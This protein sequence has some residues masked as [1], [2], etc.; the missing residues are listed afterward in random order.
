MQTLAKASVLLYP[1]FD[2][3]QANIEKQL[4]GVFGGGSSSSSSKWGK[5]S[6]TAAG[7]A[8]GTAFGARLG[9]IAG[10]ASSVTSK[11]METLS[12]SLGSAVS[13]TD[14]LNQFPKVMQSLGYSTDEA[15]S[16]MTRLSNGID[17]LPTSLDEI[18]SNTQRLTNV[19][20]DLDYSTSTAIALNDAFLACSASTSDASRGME[21][22]TQMLANGTVDAQS[23]RSLTETMGGS[24][25]KVAEKLGYASTVVGGDLYTALQN[26]TLS[27]DDLNRA[28]I[29]CDTEAGGFADT[30]AQASS[31]IGTSMSIMQTAVTSNMAKVLDKFA[32]S[33]IIDSFAQ[34]FKTNLAGAGDKAAE[35]AGK[36]VG[37]LQGLVDKAGGMDNFV[38]I[39]GKV[40]GAMAGL[41]IGS[42]ILGKLAG[43]A[44]KVG[45]AA[46]K[47]QGFYSKAKL[48][49]T[50]MTTLSGPI[51]AAKTAFEVLVGSIP[52][53]SSV[54]GFLASPIG[55]V[56]GVALA[57]GAGFMYMWS[58]SETFR[59]SVTQLLGQMQTA[60]QPAF[61]AFQQLLVALQPVLGV[62]SGAV[63]NFGAILTGVILPVLGNIALQVMNFVATIMPMVSL[64][65]QTILQT[66][67]VVVQ[68]IQVVI[69][70]A[71]I[72]IQAIVS[73]V[74][75]VIQGI[76][77]AAW[78]IIYNVVGTIFGIILNVISAVL[79][80]ISA[81]I[82]GD[83][84]SI[85]SI[86]QSAW[87]N[88]KQILNNAWNGIK[89]G[90]TQGIS[91]V[92]SAVR[93]IPS[94]ITSALGNVGT[95]LVNAGKSIIG[96]LLDGIKAK[97]E[98]VKS[99]VS[100]IAGTIASLKG[101][102]PYDRIL[103]IP[104]GQA[105]VEGLYNGIAGSIGTVYGLVGGIAGN[106]SDSM[107]GGITA[108]L[109]VAATG[110]V[111]GIGGEGAIGGVHQTFHTKVVRS[112]ADL[113]SAAT[114]LNHTALKMAGA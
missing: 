62:V 32:D 47:L 41:S 27:F 31:G 80:T 65:I 36:V 10:I 60:L 87:N 40:V 4:G 106:I 21:Q 67:T 46:G 71:M 85:K 75:G 44:G 52:G 12:N 73:S 83:L 18:V 57:L 49:G 37:A 58:T 7:T 3:L 51:G 48:I 77:Q 100:G 8:Y 74:M 50:V 61:T 84:S 43:V 86:W 45:G 64:G 97:F 72:M 88:C 92:I 78:S 2:N 38:S 81:I 30:A 89:T 56:A 20:G 109:S 53:V 68:T 63:S 111:T 35:F 108:G 15:N 94:K 25:N 6:G 99:F 13:R 112:D 98:S 14:T 39:L 79:S 91:K 28:F 105:I 5:S 70:S 11:A 104:A 82:N 113:Y 26:G 95:L 22:Y 33:G 55:I 23:W 59:N 42:G 34:S 96:G 9:A 16:A 24:L 17:G 66:V 1:K 54:L 69:Q 102:L 103:L 110:R 114:I 93:Q 19:T 76:W 29:E 107:G 101:P 90:V